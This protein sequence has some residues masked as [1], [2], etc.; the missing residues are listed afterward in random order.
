MVIKIVLTGGP[1]SGKTKTIESLKERFFEKKNVFRFKGFRC[2]FI[3]ETASEL[4]LGGVAPTT[5]NSVKSFQSILFDL[6]VQ[7]EKAF[8]EAVSKIDD[9][10]FIIFYD[11]GLVDGGA[12]LSDEEFIDL[13]KEKGTDVETIYSRYDAVI[14]LETHEDYYSTNNNEARTETPEEAKRT[15]ERTAFLWS[16]H[17]NYLFVPAKEK[18]SE[19][20]DEIAD[21]VGKIVENII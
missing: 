5:C 2:L 6:Q 12:Y 4:I 14:S 13:L 19:K 21:L 8:D 3:P 18:F 7:K 17:E 10:K 9:E 15:N 16:G 20:V 1:G 11:R